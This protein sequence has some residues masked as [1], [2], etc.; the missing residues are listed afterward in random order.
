[1]TGIKVNGLLKPRQ[2]GA[3]VADP[4][5][6]V[7]T[8][9]LPPLVTPAFNQIAP[10]RTVLDAGV[11]QA[12]KPRLPVAARLSG[13]G[14]GQIP[15]GWAKEQP[16]E[17]PARTAVASRAAVQAPPQ[18]VVMQQPQHVILSPTATGGDSSDR[19]AALGVA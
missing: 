13:L 7:A 3:E 18:Q 16:A 12:K 10:P 9:L 19:W 17:S 8:G 11:P 14:A 15:L 6:V 2:P 1:M 5:S 4:H